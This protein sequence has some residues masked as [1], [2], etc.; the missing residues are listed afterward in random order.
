MANFPRADLV[1]FGETFELSTHLIARDV[2]QRGYQP[3]WFRRALFVVNVAGRA[4]AWNMTRCVVTSTVGVQLT[5]KNYARALLKSAGLSVARGGS[6]A[7]GQMKIAM[8]RTRHLWPVVIKPA[9][10]GAGR[11]VTVGVDSPEAFTKAWDRASS[12]AGMVVVERLQEGTEAR[13]LTVGGR[14]VAVA[15]RIPANVVGDGSSTVAQLVD[16]KNAVRASNPHLRR[17]KLVA[18]ERPGDVPDSGEVVRLDPWNRVSFAAGAD[19]VDL[20]DVVHP[21]YLDL[22]GKAEFAIPGLGLSGVDIIAADFTKP[23]TADNYIIVEINSR[24][25]IGSH[26]FPWKGEPRDA[27]GAIVSAVM[28]PEIIYLDEDDP[29][30]DLD[31]V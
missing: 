23:A 21:S 12:A 25:A 15:G 26:H 18:H 7:P 11:G 3:R 20:T 9:G 29:E 17:Y 27:A 4:L 28:E 22:A 14:T 24:P 5:R 10:Q 16:R 1:P 6:Y 13:F 8:D 30:P 19:S 2:I 31:V